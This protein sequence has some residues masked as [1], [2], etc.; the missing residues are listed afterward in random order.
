[1][2]QRTSEDV[3]VMLLEMGATLN[4]AN[5]YGMTPLHT[6]CRYGNTTI[7]AM[8]L[9]RGADIAARDK[10]GATPL[11]VA[12]QHGCQT[13]VYRLMMQYHAD[14]WC[15]KTVRLTC[16]SRA[17]VRNPAQCYTSRCANAS[18]CRCYRP[19]QI[20]LDT[21][22]QHEQT[23]FHMQTNRARLRQPLE[24]EEFSTNM[25]DKRH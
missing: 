12:C 18:P 11:H 2:H 8:L 13:T 9:D 20:D 25:G 1:M 24:V 5:Q 3:V 19:R 23:A 22:I 4:A 15:L 14:P 16:E 7:A 21:S 10:L 17:R 6:S